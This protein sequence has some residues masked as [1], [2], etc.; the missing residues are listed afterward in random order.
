MHS[1][2]DSIN[3]TV[4][5]WKA[6]LQHTKGL[7]QQLLSSIP[8]T[9]LQILT[10]DILLSEWTSAGIF[11]VGNLYRDSQLIPFQFLQTDSHITSK[12]FFKYLQLCSVLSSTK[13]SDDLTLWHVI[14]FYEQLSSHCHG[15]SYIYKLL[16]DVTHHY[17]DPINAPLG[18]TPTMHLHPSAMVSLS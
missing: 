4:K 11:T 10:P 17:K 7:P 18:T 8:L 16:T 14:K 6:V 2:L 15:I 3:A 9:E 13:W 1:Y 5:T 12:D